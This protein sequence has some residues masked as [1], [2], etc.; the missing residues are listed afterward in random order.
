MESENE[1]PQP[2][3]RHQS[4]STSTGNL[5]FDENSHIAILGP[6]ETVLFLQTYKYTIVYVCL[7]EECLVNSQS[8][9]VSERQQPK[10]QRQSP[11][12]STGNVVA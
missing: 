5:C 10:K 3:K 1:T 11:S 7:S 8:S 2:R 12:T 4:P 6:I 9:R